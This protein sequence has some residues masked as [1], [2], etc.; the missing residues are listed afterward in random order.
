M[1][2]KVTTWCRGEL[3]GADVDR[4][5]RYVARGGRVPLSRHPAWPEVLAQGLSQ[6]PFCLEAR[7]EGATCGVLALAFVR[8][9]LFGRF[10]VG[11]PYLNYGGAIA[12]DDDSAASLVDQAVDLADRLGVRYLELRHERAVDHPLLSEPRAGGK[13]HMRMDLPATPEALWDRVPSKV[14]NQVRKGRNAGLTVAWG[15]EDLVGEFY[16]VFS[17]NM[18]DLGT[19]VYGRALFREI[20]A[21]FPGRSELCVVRRGDRP[22]ASAL[23]LHG[24]GVT[25]VPSASSLRRFNATNC[26]MLLYWHLLERA[27]ERGQAEFDFGRS[28]PESSTY[29]FKKQWGA[30]PHPSAWQHYLR[31]GSSSDMRPDNPRYRRFVQVW[32]KLPVGLTRLIGPPIVRGI[33]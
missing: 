15:G 22:V 4:L 31:A 16:G 14:R 27:V 30:T 9:P 7:R 32:Q 21:R 5:E 13:V 12:D 23:L 20:L 6:V 24:W 8:G 19:P 11:L 2:T 33:P 3:I 17:R 1:D 26:N 25:E 18:R 28:T 29:R 10:L